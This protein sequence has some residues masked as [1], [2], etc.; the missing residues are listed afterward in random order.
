MFF[1]KEHGFFFVFLYI[2]KAKN[3]PVNTKKPTYPAQQF[4]GT[5]IQR[6]VLPNG[7]RIV[8][9]RIPFVESFSL[10]FMINAG[11]RDDENFISGTAHFFEH[12][13]FRRTLK[14]SARK[15]A[16]DFENIGAY[17]N[18]FTTKETVC[19]YVRALTPY[20]TKI[21]QQLSDLVL[22]PALSLSDIEKERGVIIE[23]IKSYNE[24]PEE[25]ISDL[26]ESILFNN[27]SLAFPI[28]GTEESVAS[29]TEK[30]L[31]EFHK[32]FFNPKSIIIS[33]TGNID[34]EKVCRLAERYFSQEI[35]QKVDAPIRKLVESTTKGNITY[36]EKPFQQ[37]HILMNALT[38]DSLSNDRYA[39][40]VYNYALGEGMSSRLYQNIRERFGNTYTIYS[41]LQLLTDCGTCSIYAG[42]EDSTIKKV[43]SQ[44]T[45]ELDSFS[46]KK[47]SKS[48]LK[49]SKEQ[50]KTSIILSM[51]SMSSLMNALLKTEADNDSYEN[52]QTTLEK[53]DAVS[54]E[55]I[56]NISQQYL[57]PEHWNTVVFLPSTQESEE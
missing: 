53:I 19:F 56:L 39:L 47:V 30:T 34:H 52:V 45:K 36:V 37:A 3:D 28:A 22:N 29:I 11:S 33:A 32:T 57:T 18:A 40:S 21:F 15:I 10:G 50:L 49:R 27:H 42:L 4:L 17:T 2:L 8:T 20:F 48:E 24:D 54:E 46:Q 43:R 6:T 16:Q 7:L 44:I 12:I 35:I 41:S 1:L 5:S 23:E 13:A 26:G 55:D 9:E 25:L 38:P 31:R 14:R 51:E